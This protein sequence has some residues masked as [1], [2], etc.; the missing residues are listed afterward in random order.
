MS[1]FD[2]TSGSLIDVNIGGALA[3]GIINPLNA[4]IDF[5]LWG[6]LGIGSI[7]A[8]L[9]A[10]LQAALTASFDIGLNISNPYL[11]FQLALAGI[12][13][14]QGQI[15][16]AL[17]G[18]LPVISLDATGQLAANAALIANLELRLGG[19]KVILDGVLAVKLPSIQFA[20]ELAAALSAGPVSVVAWEGE[21]TSDVVNHIDTMMTGWF[22]VN[23]TY[24]ILIVTTATVAWD[25]IK[26]ILKV[27]P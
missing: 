20:A 25:G 8:D 10:Q 1:Y 3:L 6:S 26:Y 15:S 18:A 14:L 9:D 4:Q 7:Y 5:A 11:G 16:A 23:P 17:A 19:L 2:Y 12:A 13:Q 27:T 22:G 24:G 21:V